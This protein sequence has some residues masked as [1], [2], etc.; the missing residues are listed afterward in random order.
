M[1]R[2]STTSDSK[3]F[4]PKIELKT[5][6]Y[7]IIYWKIDIWKRDLKSKWLKTHYSTLLRPKDK[8]QVKWIIR[9]QTTFLPL[10][11]P[12]CRN[13]R[14]NLEDM[15]EL[16]KM[17]Q[18]SVKQLF[19]KFNDSLVFSQQ[20]ERRVKI[21]EVC[22]KLKESW[23]RSECFPCLT[24]APVCGMLQ[25]QSSLSYLDLDFC[26]APWRHG[27]LSTIVSKWCFLQVRYSY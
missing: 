17:L 5:R 3:S 9:L 23:G 12:L 16:R 13:Q 18:S 21:K 6:R 8:S 25:S 2:L 7:D 24:N 27:L 4:S 22:Y 19:P 15:Q 11:L 20:L 10:P 14:R 26:A 1:Q